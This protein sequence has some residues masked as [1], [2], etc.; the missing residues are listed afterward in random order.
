MGS[1]SIHCEEHVTFKNNPNKMNIDTLANLSG[2][3]LGFPINALPE[4]AVQ[5]CL[6]VARS[7]L[8][9]DCSR[10]HNVSVRCERFIIESYFSS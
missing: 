8:H 7:N 10:W 2:I 5:D 1:K 9:D 3:K 4:E 6:S